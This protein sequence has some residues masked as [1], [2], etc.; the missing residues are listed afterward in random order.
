MHAPRASPHTRLLPEDRVVVMRRSSVYREQRRTSVS[1]HGYKVGEGRAGR[2]RAP[3]HGASAVRPGLQARMGEVDLPLV[4]RE[5][6]T[7]A[8]GA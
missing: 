4:W 6:D 1:E 5:G 7:R 8:S 3:G 2:V